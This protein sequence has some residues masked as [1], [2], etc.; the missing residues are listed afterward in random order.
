MSHARLNIDINMQ[1]L[2]QH[3]KCGKSC[4][5]EF[6]QLI[7]SRGGRNGVLMQLRPYFQQVYLCEKSKAPEFVQ[8]KVKTKEQATRMKLTELMLHLC[9]RAARHQGPPP[10]RWNHNKR[11]LESSR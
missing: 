4:V 6:G 5:E 7:S 8:L 1:S 11:N 9:S 3:L 2:A 10:E